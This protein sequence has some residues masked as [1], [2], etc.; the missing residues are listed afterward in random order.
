[1]TLMLRGTQ[2]SGRAQSMLNLQNRKNQLKLRTVPSRGLFTLLIPRTS[3]GALLIQGRAFHT[4][5]C[6][7]KPVLVNHVSAIEEPQYQHYQNITNRYKYRLYRL[8]E[9]QSTLW[10]ERRND[11]LIHNSI[12]CALKVGSAGSHIAAVMKVELLC[13]NL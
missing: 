13:N 11:S 2:S 7:A 1:M 12:Q 10:W 3:V 4:V 9:Y 8:S 6:I 5:V